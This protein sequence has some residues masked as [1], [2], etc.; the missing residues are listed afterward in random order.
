VFRRALL[1]AVAVAAIVTPAASADVL[2][3]GGGVTACPCYVRD[4]YLSGCAGPL[5]TCVRT[6][7]FVACI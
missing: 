2:I 5:I 6:P 1:A 7:D 4:K 3:C